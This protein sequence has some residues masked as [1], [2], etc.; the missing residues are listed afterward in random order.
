[1]KFCI[2][3]VYFEFCKSV[4]LLSFSLICLQWRATSRQMARSK[5]AISL[6]MVILETRTLEDSYLLISKYISLSPR[7]L[8]S[9]CLHFQQSVQRLV[10]LMSLEKTTE[11][12]ERL[13]Y[14]TETVPSFVR[15]FSAYFISLAT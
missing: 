9:S 11:Q 7:Q 14:Y 15:H 10:L 4:F 3:A 12:R 5:E 13:K 2:C 1:M 6:N 8:K